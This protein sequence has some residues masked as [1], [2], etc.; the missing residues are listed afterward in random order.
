MTSHVENFRSPNK[1]LSFTIIILLLAIALTFY[2][3]VLRLYGLGDL[4]ILA[5]AIAALAT[6]TYSM[7]DGDKHD[8][9]AV[10]QYG[11]YLS[12]VPVA[13]L[14]AATTE[15]NRPTYT[16]ML[17]QQYLNANHP[18]WWGKLEATDQ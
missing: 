14:I 5:I 9:L 8:K 17:I 11:E 15:Q 2:L 16:K 3:Y 1:P 6:L 18:G 10:F 7:I 12:T 13:S 4:P